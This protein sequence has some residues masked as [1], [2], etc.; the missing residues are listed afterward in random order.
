[1]VLA[2]DDGDRLDELDRR[3]LRDVAPRLPDEC[4]LRVAYADYRLGTRRQ[5][6]ALLQTP[7]IDE[8]RLA[9]LTGSAVREW[10]ARE[11]LST[12]LDGEVLAHTGGFPIAVEVAV[13]LL[14][15]RGG[16]PR[17]LGPV[18]P[19]DLLAR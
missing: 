14:H 7:E 15:V 9:P 2:L 11:H 5:I 1:M 17:S 10:L 19:E 13:A 3:L 8:Y 4:Q 12:S 16:K 18:M 6:D